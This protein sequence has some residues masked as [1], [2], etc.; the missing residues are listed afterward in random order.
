MKNKS[1]NKIKISV[2]TI[3]FILGLNIAGVAPILGVLNE[4][5]TQGTSGIQLLQTISQV[6]VMVG[7]MAIGWMTTKLSK[8]KL[9][10]IG[11]IIL[12]VCGCLPF[13]FGQY[14]VIFFSRL[15]MGFGFGIVS[16][17]NTAIIAE[18]VEYDKRPAYLG[19]HVTGM[20]IGAFVVN[21]FG[22]FLGSFGYQYYFL[23]HLEIL[24]AIFI[25]IRAL[26]E[27]NLDKNLSDKNMKLNSK[28]YKISVIA[29]FDSLFITVFTT[30][31]GIYLADLFKAGSGIAGIANGV[32]A[33]FALLS[34]ML[35]AKVTGI[36]KKHTLPASV[37]I[38]AAAYIV[39]IV[40]KN[41]MIGI[42]VGCAFAGIA[43]S[44]FMAMATLL[45]SSFVKTDAV[46]KASG[47]FNVFNGCGCLLSPIV[48]N[49]ISKLAL[50]SD[51]V[52][53][54]YMVS[55]VGMLLLGCITYVF[56]LRNEENHAQQEKR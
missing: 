4:Q 11:F 17:L 44:S 20:G 29:F 45:L 5:F 52:I 30:N 6:L 49:Y 26:P 28:V 12:V 25:I 53:N 18:Y 35:F 1:L 41:N 40:F 22:G 47:I 8:K 3:A 10:L 32:N 23:I 55:I 43:L 38:G 15:L 31:I 37:F 21:L 2:F 27:G 33:I 16:P 39:L 19:L 50:G 14:G 7:A 48:V 13:F 9:I 36:L 54:I 46:A 42:F 34:G 51:S 56:V 24:I